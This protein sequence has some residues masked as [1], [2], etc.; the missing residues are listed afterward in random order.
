MKPLSELP[1]ISSTI[2][3]LKNDVRAIKEKVDG[4]IQPAHIDNLQDGHI[5]DVPTSTVDVFLLKHSG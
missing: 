2:D 4:L 1:K 3:I 5:C